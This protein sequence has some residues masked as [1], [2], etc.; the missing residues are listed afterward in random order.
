MTHGTNA[1][2]TLALKQN[3]QKCFGLEQNLFTHS[4]KCPEEMKETIL[5]GL[6]FQVWLSTRREKWPILNRDLHC[7]FSVQSKICGILVVSRF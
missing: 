5:R 4:L 2:S 6:D 1:M 7:T 3:G